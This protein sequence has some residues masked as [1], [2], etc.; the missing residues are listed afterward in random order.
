MAGEGGVQFCFFLSTLANVP[1]IRV[2][3]PP[4]QAGLKFS[5]EYHVAG[6]KL[7]SE[8]TE[9]LA[10]NATRLTIGIIAI[11]VIAGIAHIFVGALG[12]VT[13]TK[14]WPKVVAGVS[15][16]FGDGQIIKIKQVCSSVGS[17]VIS[18][19]S[20]RARVGRSGIAIKRSQFDLVTDGRTGGRTD[21]WTD[22]R[23]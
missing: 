7:I 3:S 13:V 6:G 1:I 16:P 8:G 4:S 23:D 5:L 12:A 15:H 21:R 19:T 11:C 14:K 22:G 9:F 20:S 18:S 2:S 17:S 10:A